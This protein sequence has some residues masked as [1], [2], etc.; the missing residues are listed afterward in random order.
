VDYAAPFGSPIVAAGAGVVEKIDQQPG[1][2]KYVRI[3]HDF[4]YE[5]TYAHVSGFPRSLK[6]GDRV[7]QGQT[8][9]YVGST[10]LSTGPHLYYELR[11]NGHNVDPLRARIGAGRILSEAALETFRRMRERTDQLLDASND[12]R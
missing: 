2:G 7:H 5:T 4:G 6:I 3:R 1:Y 11:I 12:D 9:A 8:I 10:G